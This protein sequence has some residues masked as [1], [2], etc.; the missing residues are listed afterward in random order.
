MKALSL[1]LIVPHDNIKL[2]LKF[3]GLRFFLLQLEN[4]KLYLFLWAF[5]CKLLYIITIVIIYEEISIFIIIFIFF[6]I[7]ILY[8]WNLLYLMKNFLYRLLLHRF[9]LFIFL[10]YYMLRLDVLLWCNYRLIKLLLSNL[11]IS[12][13]YYIIL[14]AFTAFTLFFSVLSWLL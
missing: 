13:R 6:I 7:V 4:Q 8:M 14:F 3:I 5:P 2:Y 11:L 1:L 10:F 9:C 12:C